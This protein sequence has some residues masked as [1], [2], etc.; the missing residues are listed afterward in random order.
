MAEAAKKFAKP[1]AAKVL[2]QAILDTALE[3]ED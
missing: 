2:A 1:D 3:H